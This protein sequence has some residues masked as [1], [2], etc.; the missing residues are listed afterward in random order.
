MS[1]FK[2]FSS[3]VC[4]DDLTQLEQMINAWMERD[5]PQIYLTAQS[6]FGTH[7]VVSFVFDDAETDESARAAVTATAV[8]EV[9]ERTLEDSDLDPRDTEDTDNVLLP[10]AELPY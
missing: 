1:R 10:E 3:A 2:T 8:P 5:R 4:G 9:F 7:L 6:P